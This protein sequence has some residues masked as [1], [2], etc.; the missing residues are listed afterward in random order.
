[1]AFFQ[2]LVQHPR[3]LWIRRALFQVHLWL[4][5]LLSLYVAVIGLSGSVIVWEDEIDAH[6]YRHVRYDERHLAQPAQVMANAH[7]AYPNETVTYFMFPQADAPVYTVYLRDARNEKRIVRANASTGELLPAAN[8]SFVDWVHELHVYLLMGHTGFVINCVAGIGIFV[9]ALTGIALWW[10]GLRLWMRGFYLSLHHNWKRINYDAH[11]AIGVWTLLIVSMW[12]LTSIDFLWPTQTTAA[13]NAVLPIR[14]MQ[15]PIAIK[16]ARLG[17]PASLQTIVDKAHSLSPTAFLSGVLFPIGKTGNIVTYM[18][19]A[20]VGDYT[21]RDIHT[22]AA[23]GT[24]LTTWHYGH[25][26]TLGDWILWL[27]NPLHF[28]TLWGTPVKVL[29]SIL[30][31]SLPA[32]SITGLLMYWNRY[33]GKRWAKLSALPQRGCPRT[34]PQ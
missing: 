14:G 13:V 30:G 29:W 25:N 34:V 19:T 17:A 23:D 24:L 26:E 18:D 3:K 8:S 31:L 15:A 4:G 32:L 11:S 27:V 22:F 21:H 10:P 12:G 20:A 16:P 9:L 6:A 7:A 1:M 33:L 5:V 28:G 2:T